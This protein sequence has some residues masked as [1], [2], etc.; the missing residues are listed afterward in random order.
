V[1]VHRYIT[2]TNIFL[3]SASILLTPLACNENPEPTSEI[4]S[5]ES[6]I[7]IDGN[8]D[9]EHFFTPVDLAVSN[10]GKIF[11]LDFQR[12][13]ILVF[14]S[15]GEFMYE[16]GGQG[17]GPGEFSGLYINFD[18]DDDGLVYTID[19]QNMI[20]VFNNDGSHYSSI[21]TNTGQVFDIAA[22]DSNRIY[23]NCFPFGPALLNSSS[24][25][26]VTLID[27]NGE[28]I[29]EI[30]ILETDSENLGTR[31]MLFSCVVDIDEDN[32]VYY[33]SLGKYQVFKYDSTG[34]F[35]WSTEGPSS[36][37]AYSESVE[38]GNLLYPVVWDLDVDQERVYVLWAQD[39]NE[40]GYRVDVFDSANG[41]II[42]YFYS[43]TPSDEKNM[44]IEINGDDFYT[45]DYDNG[46]VHRYTI[47]EQE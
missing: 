35:V 18:L 24:L 26:A 7:I 12:M 13:T 15:Q 3:I 33:T 30:G 17:G 6:D 31:K 45:L 11:I 47:V 40:R 10:Q 44:A 34:A 37:T 36:L 20:Q 43:Q 22:L 19:N 23:I 2:V 5:L 14:N 46:F 32:A 9:L 28:V 25:P 4:L 41:E 29:R 27:G 16:F 8:A 39:G 1:R 38:D 42:G 21:S